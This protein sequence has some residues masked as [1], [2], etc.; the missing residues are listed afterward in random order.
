MKKK[1]DNS[2]VLTIENKETKEKINI[3]IFNEK[4]VLSNEEF[5]YLF[6]ANK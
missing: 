1:N 6:N 5:N 3:L 4:L 2:R